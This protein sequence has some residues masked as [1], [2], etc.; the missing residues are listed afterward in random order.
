MVE[1]D[2]YTYRLISAWEFIL[3]MKLYFYYAVRGYSR[4]AFT[5][6][7]YCALLEVSVLREKKTLTKYYIYAINLYTWINLSENE[8]D[9]EK[10]NDRCLLTINVKKKGW[11]EWMERTRERERETTEDICVYTVV[12]TK[13][14]TK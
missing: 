6:F 13:A 7:I 12:A 5:Y 14:C 8:N 9:K 11:D 4:I 1:S 10:Y 2:F 3:L